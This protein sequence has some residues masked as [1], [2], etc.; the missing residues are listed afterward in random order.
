M[1]KHTIDVLDSS[2][3]STKLQDKGA[4]QTDRQTDNLAMAN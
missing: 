1:S 2:S 4:I 3:V